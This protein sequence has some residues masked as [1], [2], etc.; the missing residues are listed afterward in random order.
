MQLAIK[1]WEWPSV[2]FIFFTFSGFLWPHS[3][4]VYS[5]PSPAEVRF[6]HFLR[7]SP[8]LLPSVSEP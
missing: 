1:V 6:F 8:T 5:M 3:L 2:Q 7:S 4:P